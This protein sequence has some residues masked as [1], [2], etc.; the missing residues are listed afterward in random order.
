MTTKRTN[1]NP[2][3]TK[4]P[5]RPMNATITS[6]TFKRPAALVNVYSVVLSDGRTMDAFG[7]TEEA[8]IAQVTGRIAAEAHPEEAEVVRTKSV[9]TVSDIFHGC[10]GVWSYKFTN[11]MAEIAAKSTG[12]ASDIAARAKR[13]HRITIAQA[14]VLA[15]VAAANN[16]TI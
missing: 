7:S 13:T 2:M 9:A 8:A 10:S 11:M 3:T 1:P 12:I 14:E 16:I 15:R 5:K 4:T 6:I